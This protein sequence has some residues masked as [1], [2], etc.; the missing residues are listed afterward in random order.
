MKDLVNEGRNLQDNFKTAVLNENN[1]NLLR[2]IDIISIPQELNDV[3]DICKNEI[4]LSNG[5][6]SIIELYSKIFFDCLM[7]H[8]KL[9]YGRVDIISDVKNSL[10]KS[11]DEREVK[12]QYKQITKP[13]HIL[14]ADL[15]KMWND[16]KEID[17]IDEKL[18]E[19]R[20]ID[21]MIKL[22]QDILTG[23]S[24]YSISFKKQLLNS[25]INVSG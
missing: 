9:T 2:L 5:D 22:V 18:Q 19:Y 14:Q 25:K 7:Q 15:L 13:T 12:L 10:V 8:N 4:D 6:L 24:R 3:F 20:I 11:N 16:Y 21:V 1:D 23:K 17:F